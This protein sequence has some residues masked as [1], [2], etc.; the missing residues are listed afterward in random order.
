MA[1]LVAPGFG[2]LQVGFGRGHFLVSLLFAVMQ[3]SRCI[4]ELWKVTQG[5]NGPR[6]GNDRPFF[7]LKSPFGMKQIVDGRYEIGLPVAPAQFAGKCRQKTASFAAICLWNSDDKHAQHLSALRIGQQVRLS[8][9]IGAHGIGRGQ[10]ER[11]GR[12]VEGIGELLGRWNV[13]ARGRKQMK[14]KYEEG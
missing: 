5:V 6:E 8:V 4:A 14:H 7:A 3:G 12:V 10:A 2:L 13:G 9:Q 1:Q 11:M